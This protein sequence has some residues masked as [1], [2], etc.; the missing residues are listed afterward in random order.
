MP[1][2]TVPTPARARPTPPSP[3]P[4]DQE[5]TDPPLEGGSNKF[6]H[7]R[8]FF[9][10]GFDTCAQPL[11]EIVVASLRQFR[12]SLKGRVESFTERETALKTVH[13]GSFSHRARP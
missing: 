10:E 13:D 6:E 11:P 2:I 5:Q 8:E 7:A 4:A 9:G 1:P 3:P 12:P